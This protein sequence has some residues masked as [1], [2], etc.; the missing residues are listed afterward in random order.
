M[1]VHGL[2]VLITGAGGAGKSELALELL[3]RGHCLVADDAPEFERRG[4]AILGRCPPLL[5]GFLEARSLGILNVRRLFGRLS[6]RRSARLGLIVKLELDAPA[7]DS[8]TERLSGRRA[9]TELLGLAIPT[10]TLPVRAGHSLAVLVEAACADQRLRDAGYHAD[11]DLAARQ[12]RAI[13]RA[14]PARPAS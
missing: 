8:D 3:G 11:R 1:R 7:A 6:T 9:H 2:G 14:K 5:A 10:V 4:T 13:R 12:L